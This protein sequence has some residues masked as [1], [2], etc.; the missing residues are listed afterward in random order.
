LK[1]ATGT[2]SENSARTRTSKLRVLE[3]AVGILN[4]ALAALNAIRFGRGHDSLDAVGAGLFLVMAVL[5]F[6]RSNRPERGGEPQITALNIQDSK[7]RE[8]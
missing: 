6:Y 5:F 2:I 1:E 3:I 8:S 7:E 4:L